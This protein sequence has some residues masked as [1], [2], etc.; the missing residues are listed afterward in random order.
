LPIYI[1]MISFASSKILIIYSQ[2]KFLNSTKKQKNH[3]LSNCKGS[4]VDNLSK[5]ED[6]KSIFR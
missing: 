4:K 6:D 5:K 1:D 3:K 2:N